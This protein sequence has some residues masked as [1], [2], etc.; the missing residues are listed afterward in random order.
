MII[1]LNGLAGAGVLDTN[2]SGTPNLFALSIRTC[3]LTYGFNSSAFRPPLP[4]GNALLTDLSSSAPV[5]GF[6]LP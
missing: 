3:L 1:D 2:G 4:V 6:A 5:R